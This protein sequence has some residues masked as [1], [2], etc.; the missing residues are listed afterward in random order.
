PALLE[1]RAV[2]VD[3]LALPRLLGRAEVVDHADGDQR[4]EALVRLPLHEVGADAEGAGELAGVD[5]LGLRGREGD[6]DGAL[7][8]ARG[9][10]VL[11]AGAPAAP[12]VEH[13]LV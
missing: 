12:D 5:L 6:A 2:D 13:L 8:A 4:V 11:E 7:H 1:V 10:E 3:R 9:D